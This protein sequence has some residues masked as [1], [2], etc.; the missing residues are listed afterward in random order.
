MVRKDVTPHNN[1]NNA[2]KKFAISLLG[3]LLGGLIAFG[4]FYY[5]TNGNS[6]NEATTTSGV[7]DENNKA[8]V[9][10]VKVK[11]DSDTTSA[12]KKVQNAVVSVINLQ[13]SST[14]E[15]GFGSTEQ[16]SD[17]DS[18]LE[19]ASEGSGVIY[20]KD[21]D[22]AY[23]VTNNHVV[24]NQKGLEVL[25]ADGTRE[26][27]KLVGTDAFSDLAVL[28]ISADK[29]DTVATLGDSD[30][31]TVGEPAI[32]IGSP[33]G[34]DYAN[35]VTQGIISSINRLVTSQSDSGEDISIN[36]I[37]TDA[38]INPGNSGGPLINISG[39]VIG[40]NSSK[41]AS[42]GQS[43]VSVEGMGFAIPSKDVT[44]IISQLEDKGSVTRPALGITMI[45]L[46]VVS[47]EQRQSVLKLPDSIVNGVVIQN[48]G[49][50]TPASEAGLKQY[51]VITKVDDTEVS[52]SSELR[53]A[54]Y[55]KD[56][57]DKMKLTFYRNGKSQSVTVKLSEDQSIIKS[58]S[59]N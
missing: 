6:S 41:I 20:K 26:T 12:V 56:V 4:G 23:I 11:V 40:I 8:T 1:K 53:A 7:T 58:Q 39:Q 27:A 37:Q 2:L 22:K 35:S 51:D 45:D 50:S 38:A 29:V 19:T 15:W 25:L 31:L 14:D 36:A 55:K 44:K 42:S 46:N 17:S 32:A 9:S 33:L 5:F 59:N 3:G 43:G 16:D 52:D 10:N 18:D 34:S 30:E 49:K 54:L 21:D 47:S 57:G 24:A 28:T 13:N 48:V